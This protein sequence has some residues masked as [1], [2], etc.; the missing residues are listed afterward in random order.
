MNKLDN[1]IKKEKLILQLRKDCKYYEEEEKNKIKN[2]KEITL[3]KE[4][5]FNIFSYIDLKSFLNV[6]YNELSYFLFQ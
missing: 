4:N 5:W 6:F 1:K 2:L 3:S